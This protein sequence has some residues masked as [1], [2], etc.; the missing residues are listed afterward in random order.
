MRHFLLIVWETPDALRESNLATF[1]HEPF[2]NKRLMKD[3]MNDS[4]RAA[5]T[6]FYSHL[7]RLQVSS[8]ATSATLYIGFIVFAY[9]VLLPRAY[10]GIIPALILSIFSLIILGIVFLFFLRTRALTRALTHIETS[11]LVLSNGKN[12]RDWSLETLYLRTSW[13][14]RVELFLA[15]RLAPGLSPFEKAFPLILLGSAILSLVWIVIFIP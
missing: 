1:F 13:T 3:E 14:G 7:S 6:A 4:D 15:T 11:Y 5:I 8:F 12:V 2:I 10:R 9:A